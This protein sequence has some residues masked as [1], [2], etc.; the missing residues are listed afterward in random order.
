MSNRRL[1]ERQVS[2]LA[3][4]TSADTIFGDDGG[5][6]REPALRG[7]PA[8]RL[9]LVAE[10]SSGKRMAKVRSLLSRTFFYLGDG[11]HDLVREFVDAH[12][13]DDIGRLINARQFHDFL[14]ARWAE[15][16]PEPTF[17][18]D[19]TAVELAIAQVRVLNDD[20]VDNTEPEATPALRRSPYTALVRCRHDV[21]A[22]FERLD[23]DGSNGAESAEPAPD[24]TPTPT[25]IVTAVTEADDTPRV[26][27]VSEPL[28]D[29]LEAIEGWITADA[30]EA[31]F[32]AEA[33]PVVEQL[34]GD[35]VIE[36]RP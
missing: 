30:F 32:G 6:I 27:G 33:W 26:L 15:T 35:G 24:P 34:A 16:P 10:S 19:V 4:L 12:P 28:F 31:A 8:G 25:W 17:L 7:M 22:V 2:L 3:H 9:K 5:V 13:P 14:R 21:R 36:V 29:L 20:R 18:P 23:G 1:I 11:A